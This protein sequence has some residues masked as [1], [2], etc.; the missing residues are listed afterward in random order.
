MEGRPLQP[1]S[2]WKMK[3]NIPDPPDKALGNR[4]Y[5][6]ASNAPVKAPYVSWQV[7]AVAVTSLDTAGQGE[8]Q[9]RRQQRKDR[10]SNVP[11]TSI[12]LL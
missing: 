3:I 1:G 5:L 11:R 2:E 10:I 7:L 6:H 12:L 8:N 4:E 9:L